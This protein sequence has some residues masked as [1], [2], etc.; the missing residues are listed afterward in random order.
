MANEKA[1]HFQEPSIF[2]KYANSRYPIRPMIERA[3]EVGHQSAAGEGPFVRRSPCRKHVRR[4]RRYL[5]KRNRTGSS[6]RI[7]DLVPLTV[8]YSSWPRCDSTPRVVQPS[9]H[10]ERL[11]TPVPGKI[12]WKD[13]R[14]QDSLKASRNCCCASKSVLR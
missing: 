12:T 7:A 2:W 1:K 8:G 11:P 9:T 6:F 13:V 10:L 14:C 4:C 5:G 3:S